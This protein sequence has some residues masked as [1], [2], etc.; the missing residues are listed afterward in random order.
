MDIRFI[1]SL[2]FPEGGKPIIRVNTQVNG[3]T[4]PNLGDQSTPTHGVEIAVVDNLD[5]AQAFVRRVGH[6][7]KAEAFAG[8]TESSNL[9]L[10][11]VE[12][13]WLAED[14][15][16]VEVEAQIPLGDMI[17]VELVEGS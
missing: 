4:I 15:D 7:L 6:L 14:L 2:L 3:R 17:Q 13:R 1:V 16:G 11:E 5:V 10:L 8:L 9:D 12:L